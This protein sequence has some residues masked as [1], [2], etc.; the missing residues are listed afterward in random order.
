MALTPLHEA[1]SRDRFGGKA[2]HLA[3][4]LNHGLPVPSGFALDHEATSRVAGGRLSLAE[5]IAQGCW[6]V[7]SSAVDEDGAQAS[8]AGQHKSLL[9][10]RADGIDQ[11]ICEVHASGTAAAAMAYRQHLGLAQQPKMAVVLQELVPARASAVVFTRHPLTRQREIVVEA[12]WGL[13]EAVVA[14]LVVPDRFRI[15]FD[16]TLREQVAGEKDVEMCVGSDGIMEH[17]VAAERVHRLSLERADLAAITSL[18]AQL[19][20]LHGREADFDLEVAFD[21]RG[22]HLLQRREITR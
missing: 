10:V 9:G 12:A 14:G 21:E 17:A 1:L 3:Q 4:D 15:A 22:L 2:S 7:R 8:F 5:H 18:V 11:A 20:N 19:H 13:G 16:G 6:A